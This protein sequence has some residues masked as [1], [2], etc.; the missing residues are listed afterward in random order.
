MLFTAIPGLRD[1]IRAWFLC[2]GPKVSSRRVSRACHAH[3]EHSRCERRVPVV[4]RGSAGASSH[5]AS[6]QSPCAV[7]LNSRQ[8]LYVPSKLHG[9]AEP[10]LRVDSCR[11]TLLHLF[12]QTR[13]ATDSLFQPISKSII[14]TGVWQPYATASSPMRALLTIAKKRLYRAP[15]IGQIRR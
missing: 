6:P 2:Q 4:E 14:H 1:P 11:S 15:Y 13:N 5:G 10:L 9:L 8:W 7:L 12:S 3:S